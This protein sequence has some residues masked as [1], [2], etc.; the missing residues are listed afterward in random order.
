MEQ[1]LTLSSAAELGA[2]SLLTPAEAAQALR[3]SERTLERWRTTGAGPA[4]TRIGPRRI[5]YRVS[6]LLAF[7]EPAAA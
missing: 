2:R 6:D 3:V 5:A 1:S 7:A 4:A